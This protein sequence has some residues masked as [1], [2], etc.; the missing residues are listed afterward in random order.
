VAAVTVI[1]GTIIYNVRR[2]R[3]WRGF[4]QNHV[5][6]A[7]NGH[8]HRWTQATVSEVETGGRQLT[9]AEFVDLAI[10][11]RVS[12]TDLLVDDEVAP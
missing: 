8:G 4:T 5:A 9:A 1:N 7:M 11:L 3:G 6:A 2:W 10:V 12:M